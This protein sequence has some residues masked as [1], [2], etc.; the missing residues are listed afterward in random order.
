MGFYAHH[1]QRVQK[2]YYIPCDCLFDSIAYL[3]HYSQ[4]SIQLR[5]QCM[6]RFSISIQNPSHLLQEMLSI[7]FNP[8]LLFEYHKITSI[9]AYIL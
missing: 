7:H 6:N 1:L 8:T 3:L 5:Q 9:Q 4:T 2:C